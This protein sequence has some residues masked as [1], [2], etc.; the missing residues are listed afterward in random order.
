MSRYGPLLRAARAGAGGFT[1]VE[2]L[3]A[4]AAMALLA[5]MAWSGIDA[6]HRAETG[7][8]S[9]SEDLLAVQTG[10]LQ[11]RA[12]LD[13]LI[14]I[15][16]V[17]GIDF[18]GRVVR[19]TRIAQPA[20]T[21]DSAVV[22]VAWGARGIDG[23]RQ[24]LRWQS[25]PVRTRAQLELAWKQAAFWGE[26]PTDALRQQE[27]RVTGIDSWQLFYY[28]NNSWTSPLSSA[29]A[30]VAVTA[31][32]APLPDGVRLVLALSDGQ[33]LSGRLQHD[34]VR[35]TLGAAR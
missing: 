17:G 28:R 9:R 20:D 34:W 18:D 13:A 16:P 2:V 12:D 35:P 32:Q 6:M 23:L 30:Q 11:W 33:V 26:N 21:P 5:V 29:G 31:A 4:L 7:T 1:L 22:V 14:Q 8:R 24:W 27:V 10:L 3:V 25:P 15:A 19:L